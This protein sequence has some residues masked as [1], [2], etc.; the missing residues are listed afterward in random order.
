MTLDK[1]EFDSN[2]E[3]VKKVELLVQQLDK[4]GLSQQ[5]L[6]ELVDATHRLHE[7]TLIIRYKAN[8]EQV[9]GAKK[10]DLTNVQE[11]LKPET[12]AL[13][14]EETELKTESGTADDFGFELDI[15]EE[16]GEKTEEKGD[17]PSNEIESRSITIAQEATADQ[18]P[19]VE[20]IQEETHFTVPDGEGSDSF[21]SLFKQITNTHGGGVGHSKLD[22][23]VGSFGLNERLQY[24]N[25]LFDGSS[26]QFSEAIKALDVQ[27]G[28]NEAY[29]L[30]A[31][32]ADQNKWMKDS[33]TIVEFI[34]KLNRRYA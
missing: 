6:D 33:D 2:L 20:V 25:E 26:E 15:F 31:A 11:E 27:T 10:K 8:E 1:M 34:Q 3:L 24:I 14:I 28:L 9:F 30:A 4:K 16:S 22:S 17:L 13:P 12:Q 32:F 21:V 23:L 7:R 5:E 19:E 29:A 18:A